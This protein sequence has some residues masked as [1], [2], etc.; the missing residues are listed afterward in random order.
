MITNTV[1]ANAAAPKTK[2]AYSV[3]EAAEVTSMSKS[4]LRNEIRAKNLKA[5]LVGN[6]VVILNSDLQ[7]WLEGK[8]DWQGIKERNN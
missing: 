8:S 6:R 5:K 4:Y 3:A 1:E 2:I 7:V